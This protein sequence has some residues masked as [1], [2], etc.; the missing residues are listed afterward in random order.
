MSDDGSATIKKYQRRQE[1]IED[2]DK[3]AKQNMKAVISK[4]M[5]DEGTHKNIARE[6][7]KARQGGGNSIKNRSCW[8]DDGDDEFTGIHEERPWER[9]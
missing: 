2:A 5:K 9:D 8:G 7:L 1:K 3:A 4:A 6:L